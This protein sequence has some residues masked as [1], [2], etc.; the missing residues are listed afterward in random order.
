MIY[1]K[2]KDQGRKEHAGWVHD[3]LVRR[4]G[5]FAAGGGK[6]GGGDEDRKK[7]GI[8]FDPQP[9]RVHGRDPPPGG[10]PTLD[11]VDRSGVVSFTEWEFQGLPGTT[12]APR[13]APPAFPSYKRRVWGEKGPPNQCPNSPGGDP[14]TTAGAFGPLRCSLPITQKGLG[15]KT[16]SWRGRRDVGHASRTLRP[17]PPGKRGRPALPERQW[18]PSPASAFLTGQ[19]VSGGGSMRASS[20]PLS[21]P[22]PG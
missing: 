11:C 12:S 5:S 19:D 15:E 16:G 1:G 13:K 6:G 8:T 20:W 7:V 10:I 3:A 14:G 4:Q 21:T 17:A 9:R 22:W 2:K 18:P